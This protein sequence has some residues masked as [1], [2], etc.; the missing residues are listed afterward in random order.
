MKIAVRVQKMNA[1]MQPPNQSKYRPVKAG[2][3]IWNSC[4]W[5]STPGSQPKMTWLRL[6]SAQYSRVEMTVP[7]KMLPK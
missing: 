4:S 1:W 6:A 3:P 7:D 5:L 2:I